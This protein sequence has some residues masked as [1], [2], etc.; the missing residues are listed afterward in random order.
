MNLQ[1]Y[2]PGSLNHR[3]CRPRAGR[4]TH[5]PTAELSA[6]VC[7]LFFCHDR[8]GAPVDTLAVFWQNAAKSVTLSTGTSLTP[9]STLLLASPL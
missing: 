8:C 1:T 2:P 5:F 6:F 3:V 7:L 9:R 4:H